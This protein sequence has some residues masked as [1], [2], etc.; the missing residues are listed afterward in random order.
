LTYWP[1]A[2]ASYYKLSLIATHRPK[3]LGRRDLGAFTRHQLR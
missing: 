2:V 3:R 1:A